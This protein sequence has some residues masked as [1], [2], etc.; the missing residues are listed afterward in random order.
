[1]IL[2]PPAQCPCSQKLID[3][4]EPTLIVDPMEPAPPSTAAPDVWQRLIDYIRNLRK[5]NF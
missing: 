4:R 1:M 5:L 2:Y 3:P